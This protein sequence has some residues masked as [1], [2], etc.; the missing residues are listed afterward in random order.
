MRIS[1]C[2][3]P[4]TTSKCNK[5]EHRMFYDL[6]NR[7]GAVN[8]KE[9]LTIHSALEKNRS[10]T[11]RRVTQEEME[12]ASIERNTFHGEWNYTLTPHPLN[13]GVV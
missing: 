3:C 5:I 11:G 9:G 13:D 12:S 10:W 1:V 2:H 8:T 4:K 7:I 6:L